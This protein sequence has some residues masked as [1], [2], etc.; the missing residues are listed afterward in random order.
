MVCGS[1][2]SEMKNR[3]PL[4]REA[5][6][7]VKMHK[8]WQLQSIFRSWD[9]EKCTSLWREA[10][11][12]IQNTQISEH[13]WKMKC[14]KSV[15]RCGT[16][17][18][19]KSKVKKMILSHHFWKLSCWKSA[20]HRGAKHISNSKVLKTD[21]FGPILDVQVSFRVACAKIY[22]PCPKWTRRKCFVAVS[23]TLAGV[24]HLKKI[25]KHAFCAPGA[26][27]ETCSSEMFGGQGV[28]FLRR[29]A[30][31]SIGSSGL[32]RWFCVTDAALRTL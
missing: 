3:T 25:C 30:F 32:L 17:H 18:M 16:K 23:K 22:A 27:Q 11:L 6:F 31:W 28:D 12:E 14:W 21:G 20:R 7:E 24:R 5:H 29:V 19:W 15:R 9:V 26:V 2:G 8:T 13:F 10:H 1:G 4:W